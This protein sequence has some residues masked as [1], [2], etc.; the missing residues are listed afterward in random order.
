MGGFLTAWSVRVRWMCASGEL[1]MG[2]D[3]L[4]GQRVTFLSSLFHELREVP[5][6]LHWMT[7]VLISVSLCLGIYEF[8]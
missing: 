3:I 5:P 8:S 1:G 7:D 6:V 2:A 4:M